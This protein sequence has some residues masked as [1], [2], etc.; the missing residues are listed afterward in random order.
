MDKI[1]LESIYYKNSYNKINDI[2]DYDIF[3]NIFDYDDCLICLDCF[4]KS[5]FTN[6]TNCKKKFHIECIDKWIS[7]SNTCPHCRK[8]WNIP[9]LEISAFILNFLAQ[10]SI[11]SLILLLTATL[12]PS[13]FFK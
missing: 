13:F 1:F 5:N 2:L 11:T 8:Y 3:N 10:R 6:C 12:P 9:K 4:E 7:K